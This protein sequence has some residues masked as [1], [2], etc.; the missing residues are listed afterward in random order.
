MEKCGA[1]CG[2][3]EECHRDSCKKEVCHKEEFC[4]MKCCMMFML[5]PLLFCCPTLRNCLPC[6]I[7]PLVLLHVKKMMC[8]KNCEKGNCKCP[9]VK[10]CK[11]FM[12]VLGCCQDKCCFKPKYDCMEVDN[13]MVLCMDLPGMKREDIDVHVCKQTLCIGGDRKPCCCC[14]NAVCCV[15]KRK[16]G[17]FQ[18]C[19]PLCDSLDPATVN[20]K[21]E[22]GVLVVKVSKKPEC[23]AD[24]KKVNI[25]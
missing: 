1:F 18:K 12:K 15:K 14:P 19:I 4:K 5:V 8:M 24:K 6:L 16:F 7:I 20:A 21:Y 11:K 2:E 22:N 10:C 3:K 13:Q 23:V 25:E 9:F 17:H